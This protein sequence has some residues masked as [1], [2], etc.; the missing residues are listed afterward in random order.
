[1]AGADLVED[2]G[3]RRAMTPRK[4]RAQGGRDDEQQEDAGGE[5]GRGGEARGGQGRRR[6][7]AAQGVDGTPVVRETPGIPHP[8]GRNRLPESSA[9]GLQASLHVRVDRP[10][11]LS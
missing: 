10:R 3:K 5:G 11:H 8:F 7:R 2:G 4:G 6:R 1:E 9:R